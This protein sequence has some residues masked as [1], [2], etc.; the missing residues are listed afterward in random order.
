MR[1]WQV[2]VTG[3]GLSDCQGRLLMS[4]SRRIISERSPDILRP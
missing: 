1:A 4:L 2:A 3:P